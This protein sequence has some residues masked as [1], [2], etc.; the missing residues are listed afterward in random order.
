MKTSTNPPRTWQLHLADA[1]FYL[2][3]PVLFYRE[4]YRPWRASKRGE[5]VWEI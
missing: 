5:G 4:V 1:Y 2:H 3:H